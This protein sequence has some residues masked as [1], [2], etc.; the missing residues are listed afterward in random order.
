MTIRV[1]DKIT[2]LPNKRYKGKHELDEPV[3][4]GSDK[5]GDFIQMQVMDE[6][7]SKTG[8][9]TGFMYVRIHTDLK[10][11]PNDRVTVKAIT[12]AQ[13]KNNVSVLEIDIKE[14]DPLAEI[15]TM[16]E[17]ANNEHECKDEN[18]KEFEF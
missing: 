12:G 4:T 9:L 11:V 8:K 13:R 10:L 7:P 5:Y 3:G 14:T 2:L 1:G 6:T 18:T 15:E 16:E 17:Y